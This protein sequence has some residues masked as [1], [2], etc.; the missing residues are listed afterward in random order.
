MWPYLT[1]SAPVSPRTEIMIE[2][3][4]GHC[5]PGGKDPCGEYPCIGAVSTAA[6]GRSFSLGC[7][8][9]PLVPVLQII[10]GNFKL[11]LGLQTYGLWYGPRYPNATTNHSTD[12]EFDCGSGCLFDIVSS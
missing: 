2:T 4:C 3:G 7:V 12:G 9:T 1:G 11:I 8:F 10:S 5:T 6:C